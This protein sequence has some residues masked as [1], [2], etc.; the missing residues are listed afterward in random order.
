MSRLA[1]SKKPA[2]ESA[3]SRWPLLEFGYAAATVKKYR[4]AVKLFYDWCNEN[5]QDDVHDF[6]ELDERLA[7][8][9]QTMYDQNDGKG[10]Q[11]AKDTLY[12]LQLFLPR[13]KAKLVISARIASRWAKGAGVVSYPPLTWDLAVL[14]SVQMTRHG[15][16]DFGV[17][18]LLAFDCLLRVSE[19]MSLRREDVAF[20]ND[21]RM[22]AE[23]RVTTIAIRQA[24]TG[25]N[26]SVVVQNPDVVQLLRARVAATKRGGLLFRGRPATYRAL[27]KRVCSE[28]SLSHSYVPHSLRHGGATRLHL[29]SV[30][31]EDIMM[32]G[33][34]ASAK[35][36]RTYVQASRA[37][38]MATAPPPAVTRVAA[39]LS[40]SIQSAL[41]L[42]QKH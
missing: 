40:R 31:L 6:D 9:F 38:L 8:Y 12:G 26:Q 14:I 22:G 21:S 37:V 33:R 30:P 20:P 10:K 39:V 1:A 16:L 4:N 25:K 3:A 23:Y 28:L 7:D 41:S 36:A 2:R 13:A 15:R 35:S 32:R 17:A 42:A 34:W 29:R 18:T 24:K 27:F 19:L 11:L 5:F